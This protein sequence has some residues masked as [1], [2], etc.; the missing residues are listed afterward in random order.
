M[1]KRFEKTY[2]RYVLNVNGSDRYAY[3]HSDSSDLYDLK[4]TDYEIKL[5][6]GSKIFL[7]TDGVPEA[8][9]N[10][11]KM[12]GLDRMIKTLSLNRELNPE[13]LIRIVREDVDEFVEDAD[14]FDD[15]TMLCVHYK[16]IE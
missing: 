9:R 4:F 11:K 6:P 7:Y 3:S 13:N 8:T 5:E 1:I 16:G 15:I 14:Q 2:G 10:D 12:Y